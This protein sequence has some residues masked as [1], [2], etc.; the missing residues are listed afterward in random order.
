[1]VINYRKYLPYLLT[2]LAVCINFCGISNS[3]FTDDQALYASIAK[4]ILFHKNLFELFT[5]NQ[6]W[7]DKPHFPFWCIALSFKVFGVSEWA[8]RLPAL[9]FFIISLAYTYLFTRKYYS[10]DTALTAVL[11]LATALNVMMGNTDIR[12]EPYLMGLLT[13]AI[14]HISNLKDKFRYYDIL[15]AALF[16]AF[17]IMTKGVFLLIP[18]WGGLIGELLFT[19]GLKASLNIRWLGLL[20]L[21][22]VFIIPELYSLYF[23]FDLHPGKLVFGRHN[24]SGIKWFLWD[25]QFG[26]FV[27]NG[28]ISRKAAGSIFFYLHTLL[29]AFAPWCLLLYYAFYKEVKAIFKRQKLAEYYALSGGLL[30]LILFSL[31]RFQLPFYTN[32]IFPL[33]AIITARFVYVKLSAVAIMLRRIGLWLFSTALTAAVILLNIFSRPSQSLLFGADCFLL[34]F[35]ISIILINIKNQHKRLFYLACSASIFAG[36]Y[37]NT[38]FYRVIT[39]YNG[40]K[41]AAQY[42]NLSPFKNAVIYT[43][44]QDDNSFQFYCAK[45]VTPLKPENFK[46]TK[47]QSMEIYYA[48]QSTLNYLNSAHVPYTLLRS[49]INYP[50]ENILPKFIN[51]DTRKQVLNRVYIISK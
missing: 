38:I 26:R 24:V 16:M 18:I 39:S 28:P 49:F 50:Q 23:Q 20:L 31:S 36:F 48:R 21:T 22:V 19:G 14:F 7:L 41:L 13:G 2:G 35:L 6:N 12:A 34:I 42:I 3:F 27:N 5:Y 8:Y 43:L 37:L 15:F 11:I 33:F 9:L 17:A 29:W 45:P 10:S 46:D 1:M 25:S 32:A 40:Q 44:N 30:L 47:S 4:N 51:S